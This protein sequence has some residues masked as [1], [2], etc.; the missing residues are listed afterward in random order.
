[1]P[2]QTKEPKRSVVSDPKGIQWLKI[3]RDRV[4]CRVTSGETGGA[5]CVLEQIS[6]PG[7]GVPPHVHDKEDELF[8]ILEGEGEVIC[9]D[10]VIKAL[11][12]MVIYLPKKIPHAFRN[13]GQ[14][15]SRGLAIVMPGGMEN[16]FP[17]VD[18]LMSKGEATPE[19]VAGMFA[20][21]GI[22]FL[23]PPPQP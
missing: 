20:R 19:K 18:A 8:Y 17:Q 3:F 2:G 6:P 1:M 9:G 11:P 10:E 7:G 14:T 12:G 16:I 4:A 15:P 23:P 22:N 13:V 5:F 21:L